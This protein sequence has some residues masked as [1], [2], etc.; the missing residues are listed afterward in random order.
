MT[1]SYPS[2]LKSVVSPLTVGKSFGGLTG[3]RPGRNVAIPEAF[4]PK[5][6]R[7]QIGYLLP[8]S[9]DSVGI[10]TSRN[11]KNVNILRKSTIMERGLVQCQSFECIPPQSGR[12]SYGSL[13]H[14][15]RSPTCGAGGLLPPKQRGSGFCPHNQ[16]NIS[17]PAR[18]ATHSFPGGA[19]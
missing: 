18:S 8:F 4:S 6:S 10:Q 7:P 13:S 16:P 14:L 2:D 17:P 5:A 11:P 19:S 12:P 9:F 1:V 3:S 15:S